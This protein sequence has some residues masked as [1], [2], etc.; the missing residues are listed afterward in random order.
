MN[1]CQLMVSVLYNW[2][3][4]L[5]LKLKIVCILL[6]NKK[7]NIIVIPILTVNSNDLT[8]AT[9]VVERTWSVADHLNNLFF[10]CC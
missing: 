6:F 3:V 8:A 2:S 5:Y 9:V 1:K 10:C 4:R 7:I